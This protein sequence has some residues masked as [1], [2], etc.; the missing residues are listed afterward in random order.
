MAK[1]VKEKKLKPGQSIPGCN[2]YFLCKFLKDTMLQARTYLFC[3]VRPEV[4]FHKYTFAT[5]GFAQNASVIKLQPKKATS[6]QSK[7]EMQLME[8]LEKMKQMLEDLKNSGAAGGG[9]DNM[10][11]LNRMMAEKQAQLIAEMKGEAEEHK[12][13]EMNKQKKQY[14]ARGI[15]LATLSPSLPTPTLSTWT[16]TASATVASFTCCRVSAPCS[17]RRAA[18]SCRSI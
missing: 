9:G 10:D 13:A 15:A 8:E 6:A 12:R 5:L 4:E 17:A 14:D 11:E 1:A 3:A 7:R 2:T 16:R 18:T